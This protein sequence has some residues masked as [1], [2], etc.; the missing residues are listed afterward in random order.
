MNYWWVNH[1]QTFTKEFEGGYIWSP[2]KNKN[3]S[4]NQTYNNLTLTQAGDI[5]FSFANAHIKAVGVIEESFKESDR[6]VEFGSTG[7]QWNENGYLVKVNWIKL[8]DPLKP[9]NYIDELS[10]LLPQ[11]YSPIQANGDGNQGCYLASINEDLYNRLLA[12]IKRNNGYI[13]GNLTELQTTVKEQEEEQK[14]KS[15]SIPE[16]TK[17][18]LIKARVGQGLFRN[19]VIKLEKKCRVT[20]VND[21]RLLIASHIKPWSVSDDEEKLDGNNGLLLSPHVDR[22]FDKGWISFTDEGEMLIAEEV[23][24]IIEQWKVPTHTSD[25]FRANQKSYLKYHRENIFKDTPL[26]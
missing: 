4:V 12:L 21:E 23:R 19:N 9:K 20:G 5:I 1:K 13:S 18:Q 22:L 10:P 15:K 25:S 14:I 24:P 3:G 7:D 2:Q 26:Q 17:Q 11:K 8:E 6:P 16:T